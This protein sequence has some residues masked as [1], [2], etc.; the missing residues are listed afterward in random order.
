MWVQII[1]KLR[2]GLP[3][4]YNIQKGWQL[5]QVVFNSSTVQLL[6]QHAESNPMRPKPKDPKTQWD[7]MGSLGLADGQ[8]WGGSFRYP[9][10]T[11]LEEPRIQEHSLSR[12]NHTDQEKQLKPSWSYNKSKAQQGLVP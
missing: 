6:Q 2:R 1:T 12:E 10:Q 5:P 3:K 4:S 8:S 7:R 9:F 11:S